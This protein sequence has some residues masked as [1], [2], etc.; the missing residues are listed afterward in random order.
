MPDVGG[1][2]DVPG[3]RGPSCELLERGDALL[4]PARAD[5]QP[6]VEDRQPYPVELRPRRPAS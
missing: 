6:A 1:E 4:D 3:L 5:R 2:V